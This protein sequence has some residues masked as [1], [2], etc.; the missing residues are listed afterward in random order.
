LTSAFGCY[1]LELPEGTWVDLIP[2][3]NAVREAEDA[4]A[5]DDLEHAKIKSALAVSIARQPF[6]PPRSECGWRRGGA[7]APTSLGAR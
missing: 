2:A 3:A 1:R 6:L 7:S 5:K 4:L